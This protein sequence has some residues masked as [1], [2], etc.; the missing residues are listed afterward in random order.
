MFLKIK[1]IEKVFFD[2]IRD[3]SSKA[4]EKKEL[5][6]KNKEKPKKNQR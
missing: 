3:S 2:K 6:A 4:Q 1:A 5:E